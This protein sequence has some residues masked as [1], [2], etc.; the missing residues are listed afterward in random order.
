LGKN[1]YVSGQIWPAAGGNGWIPA[2]GVFGVM[3][4]AGDSQ[5]QQQ[6]QGI[7]RGIAGDTYHRAQVV[8]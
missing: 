4:G 8:A 7:L 3:S 2:T 5:V 6:V 1:N